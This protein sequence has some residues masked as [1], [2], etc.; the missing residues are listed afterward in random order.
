[1]KRNAFTDFSLLVCRS[2]FCWWAALS[3]KFQHSTK[4]V[5]ILVN[6]ELV[7]CCRRAWA[8]VASTAK[9]TGSEIGFVVLLELQE[10][11]SYGKIMAFARQFSAYLFIK[12]L[13]Q[14]QNATCAAALIICFLWLF[15]ILGLAESSK[16]SKYMSIFNVTASLIFKSLLELQP[17]IIN[18]SISVSPTSFLPSN[19]KNSTSQKTSLVF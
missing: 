10:G 19:L 4:Q 18:K 2:L 11:S 9:I 7:L 15:V 3:K 14:L 6:V 1:M 17:E 13:F 16:I 12:K 5:D 8:F